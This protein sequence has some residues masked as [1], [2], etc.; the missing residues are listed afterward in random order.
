MEGEDSECI[1]GGTHEWGGGEHM[2]ERGGRK[3]MR[4]AVILHQGQL[5]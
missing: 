2:Q 5:A 1:W 3:Q 4:G